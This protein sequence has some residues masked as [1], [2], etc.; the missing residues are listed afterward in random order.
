MVFWLSGGLDKEFEIVFRRAFASRLFAPSKI[1]ELGQTHV[2]GMI[3]YGPP[4]TGKT[5]IA[6]KL[7]ELLQVR[8]LCLRYDTFRC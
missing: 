6:T 8:A 4:G 7:S 3:L 1:K 2:K 5:L